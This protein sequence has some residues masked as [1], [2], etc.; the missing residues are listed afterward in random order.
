MVLSEGLG[1]MGERARA[2]TRGAATHR[3]GPAEGAA[4][5]AA[6]C[7]DQGRTAGELSR[8]G[9]GTCVAR[10][11]YPELQL[12]GLCMGMRMGHD[13]R[14]QHARW[15]LD[16]HGKLWQA[17]GKIKILIKIRFV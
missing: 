5:D 17:V 8:R 9:Y 6:T 2:S 7:E 16:G 14:K 10:R 12:I 4:V 3:Q 15:D 13:A 1:Y 11:N